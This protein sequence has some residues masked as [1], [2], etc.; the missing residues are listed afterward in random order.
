M[1]LKHFSLGA[2][3]L[4]AANLLTATA[5]AAPLSGGQMKADIAAASSIEKAAYRRCWWRHG[6]RVCRWVG[7]PYYDD[8]YGYYGPSYGYGPS[9][10][11]RFGGR[12]HHF[13]GHHR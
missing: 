4:I 12:G 9:F 2:A 11:F 13:H 3:G 8:D 6:Y 1:R 5:Q 7:Y 10:G